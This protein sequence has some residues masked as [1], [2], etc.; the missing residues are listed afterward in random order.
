MSALLYQLCLCIY[1]EYASGCYKG[2]AQQKR[3][4]IMFKIF[5]I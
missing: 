5:Q 2:L 4:N 3:A 1:I